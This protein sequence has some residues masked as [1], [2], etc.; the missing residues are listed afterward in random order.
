MLITQLLAKA[1]FRSTEFGLVS[2]EEDFMGLL[3]ATGQPIMFAIRQGRC[4]LKL[5]RSEPIRLDVGDM[6]LVTRGPTFH[7]YTSETAP[8]T[9]A[10]ALVRKRPLQSYKLE[11]GKRVATQ[12]FATMSVW[13][14]V[15]RE[16]IARM[17]PDVLVVRR[18]EFEDAEETAAI[19]DM[20]VREI[21][22]ARIISPLVVNRIANMLVCELLLVKYN[23]ERAREA[24]LRSIGN[25]GVVRAL[26][27]IHST[28][29][30]D[31][32]VADLAR[33]VAMSRSAFT[34]EFAATIG[35]SPGRYLID[36]KLSRAAALL[37]A[38]DYF[39]SSIAD[40]IGYDSTPSF[41]KAFRQRYGTSPNRFRE[42]AS[43]VT[44]Q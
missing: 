5:E 15:A 39:V 4:F 36:T 33:R 41:I 22:R 24:I 44:L 26:M 34:A 20:A 29:I 43:G 31:F 13:D 40:M 16:T 30:P 32:T 14:D 1:R 10:L 23:D 28:L 6:A 25:P 35:V 7:F 38:T 8:E 11:M 9:N 42:A 19:L 37:T 2:Y 3:P 21:D 27:L 18:G 17:L 12:F